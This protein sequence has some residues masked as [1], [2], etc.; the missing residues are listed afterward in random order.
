[1]LALTSPP[2]DPE[3]SAPRAHV[4]AAA[5]AVFGALCLAAF[6]WTTIDRAN[7]AERHPAWWLA[8]AVLAVGPLVRPIWGCYLVFFA[9]PFFGNHPGGRF[10]E[11]INIPVAA[12]VVGLTVR[13]WRQ[14][15]PPPSGLLWWAA[16]A[17]VASAGVALVPTLPGLIRRWVEI[18]DFGLTVIEALSA[19]EADP[20]YS[21][22]SCVVLALAVAWAAAMAWAA[23]GVGFVKNTFRSVA[24][25]FFVVLIL[26]ALDFHGVVDLQRYLLLLD[27]RSFAKLGFQSI[28]WNPGWFAWFFT[29]AFA[30][31]V[32]LS[33]LE[34][35]ILRAAISTGLLI[36][37]VYF[38][39]NRQRGGFLALHAGLIFSGVYAMTRSG[40][41]RRLA[42]WRIA[43][44]LVVG[45]ATITLIVSMLWHRADVF[46]SAKRLLASPVDPVR[47][48]LT[49]AALAIWSHA[50][51]L[52]VG[53]GLFAWRFREFI[54]SERYPFE[55]GDAHST[56]LQILATRGLMGL[57]IYVVLLGMIIWHETRA[58]RSAEADRRY[59]SLGVLAFLVIF[60]AYSFTQ[61]MFYL[62]AIQIFFWGTVASLMI[63]APTSPAPRARAAGLVLFPILVAAVVVAAVAS[64][65][66]ALA[67]AAMAARQQPHG[68][69]PVERLNA[70]GP[71]FRWSSRQ[72]ILCLYPSAN[73][74]SINGT[75][76]RPNLQPEAV[77]VSLT[78]NGHL[79]DRFDV[80]DTE[81]FQRSFYLTEH[82]TPFG[83]STPAFG[84]CTGAGAGIRLGMELTR[85]RSPLSTGKGADP[86]HLGL[87][88]LSPVYRPASA[89]LRLGLYPEET[90]AD[91]RRVRWTAARASLAMALPVIPAS[92]RIPVRA[93]RPRL[94]LR[95]VEVRFFWNTTLVSSTSLSDPGWRWVIVPVTGPDQAGVLTIQ[96]DRVWQPRAWGVN[97]DRRWLGVQLGEMVIEPA[98]AN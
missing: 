26:G 97:S 68:F 73:V 49:R 76:Y 83:T 8:L 32:A 86:R 28:F 95:P 69:Y 34:R 80:K 71:A 96:V 65:W 18:N 59:V 13:A 82:G 23:P 52:G 11:I 7:L 14:R 44:G 15:R 87:A 30:I 22:A 54:P 38:L 64:N 12:S 25:A 89:D 5:V 92:I 2:S 63:V 21:V 31:V 70:T 55:F 51:F 43:C 36:A 78:A 3:A 72:G 93:I 50:P 94:S 75:V 41:Y 48:S 4:L 81:D 33:C 27:N 67:T 20:L 29:M 60:V 57:A 42:G 91:G 17:Y 9:I 56:W 19:A 58:L 1:M 6:T 53:E 37:Y 84:E 24:A 79:V 16:A 47:S 39:F 90:D 62:P 77:T 85:A 40:A 74:V 88:L 46:I 98:P 35:G 10:M 66:P 61:Y 45:A